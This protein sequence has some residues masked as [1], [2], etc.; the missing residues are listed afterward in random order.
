[1]ADAKHWADRPILRD[2]LWFLVLPHQ[3]GQWLRRKICSH[4]YD[5]ADLQPR[6]AAGKV[7]CRC[8]KCGAILTAECGLTLPGVFDR[9]SAATSGV[10]TNRGGGHG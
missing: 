3:A 2:L 5:L 6:D 7:S 1:M 9:N 4:R 10:E 8:H